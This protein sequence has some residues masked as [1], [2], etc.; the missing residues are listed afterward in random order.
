MKIKEITI[1]SIGDSRK[2]S[3]WS[4]IPYFLSTQIEQK[5]IKINRIDI[6]PN[7]YIQWLYNHTITKI[8]KLL[9]PKTEHDYF[10]STFNCILMTLKL[11]VFQFIHRKADFDLVLS[12]SVYIL[13]RR[14]K[15]CLLSD[16]T[17][18]QYIINQ[19]HRPLYSEEHRYANYQKKCLKRCNTI[20]SLFPKSAT[21]IS[22]DINQEVF[23]LGTNVVNNCCN[24]EITH[25]II[26]PKWENKKLLF[27]GRPSY[28]IGANF[29]LEAFERIKHKHPTAE[30]HF[31]G[32]TAEH[33]G[34]KQEKEN[35]YF[36]GYL[37]RE[38]KEQKDLY[39]DLLI[40][41]TIFVNPTQEW[42][43]YSSVI[44]AMYFYTPIIVAPFNEFVN[45]FGKNI[46]FGSYIDSY[47]IEKLSNIIDSLL[48]LSFESYYQKA[49]NAHKNVK[50][51]TWE[52]FT[53][54]LLEKISIKN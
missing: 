16:W 10:T 36:Y 12:Y 51:H 25:S 6:S 30:L 23:H 39:Y 21:E 5:G 13:F 48:N 35:I 37:K 20:I 43:G 8:Y 3:T 42:G 54:C 31:I 33:L 24:T 47:S 49:L 17:L 18:K 28:A 22:R 9:H 50:N 34:I 46:E 41:S 7:R 2:V 26:N 11:S 44:E 38:N 40:K 45:E 53:D 19:K 29:L 15:V 1:F 4:G 32:I 14:K 52:Y 27:I